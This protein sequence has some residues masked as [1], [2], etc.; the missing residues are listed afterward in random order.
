[1]EYL[2][3]KQHI[4]EF[5]L[6]YGLCLSLETSDAYVSGVTQDVANQLGDILGM[7]LDVP[8]FK[9][10][11]FPLSHKKLLYLNDCLWWKM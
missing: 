1:M 3:R 8:P 7:P 11:G 5:S 4:D 10:L 6:A 2:S 9:Y